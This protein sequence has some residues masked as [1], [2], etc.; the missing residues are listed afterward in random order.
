MQLLGTFARVALPTAYLFLARDRTAPKVPRKIPH[1]CSL[2]V[3]GRS[4][5]RSS[6]SSNNC[7]APTCDASGSSLLA[8][9]AVRPTLFRRRPET[10][11]TEALR[12]AAAPT[13]SAVRSRIGV[14]TSKAVQPPAWANSPH[15]G[16]RLE[17]TSLT[18]LRR[19]MSGTGE[20]R[21]RPRHP[22]R[23]IPW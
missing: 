15:P 9:G 2:D 12:P 3:R 18:G 5:I 11:Q 13:M 17:A 14:V 10:R 16:T 21:G 20:H 8:L 7:V 1:G 19:A 6:T 4:A 23:H 22:D